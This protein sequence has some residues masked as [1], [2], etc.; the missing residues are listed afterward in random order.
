MFIIYFQL[1]QFNIATVM[2]E[3][4]EGKLITGLLPAEARLFFVL[5]NITYIYIC[6]F[7]WKSVLKC[8]TC[9]FIYC[10]VD[11]QNNLTRN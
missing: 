9:F 1:V 5:D 11:T 3:M 6:N 7:H 8:T 2:I 4:I 10:L